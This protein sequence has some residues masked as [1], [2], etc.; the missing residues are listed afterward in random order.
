MFLVIYEVPYSIWVAEKINSDHTGIARGIQGIVISWLNCSLGGDGV[1]NGKLM[2]RGYMD[3]YGSWSWLDRS[4]PWFSPWSL[5]TLQLFPMNYPIFDLVKQI[6]LSPPI[7]NPLI[8]HTKM[9]YVFQTFTIDIRRADGYTCWII[10]FLYFTILKRIRGRF[11]PSP[12]KEYTGIKHCRCNY[13]NPQT[14][15][16]VYRNHPVCLFVC[17]SIN[18][19]L[20]VDHNF[21]TKRVR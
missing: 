3:L 11:L 17:L 8:Y 12:I 4:V 5:R 20:N 9:F 15:F 7:H 16:Y 6:L 19:E 14:K 2:W 13:Y 21:W 1:V 18:L 10:M